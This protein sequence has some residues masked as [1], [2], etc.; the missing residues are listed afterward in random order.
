METSKYIKE[1]LTISDIQKMLDVGYQEAAKIIREIRYKSD[2]LHKEGRCHIQDYIDVFNLP[3]EMYME[4][5]K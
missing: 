1:C 4:E 5:K 3:Q 2:R